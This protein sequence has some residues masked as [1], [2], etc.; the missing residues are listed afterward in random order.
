[1]RKIVVGAMVSMDG[2]MQAQFIKILQRSAANTL[3][4]VNERTDSGWEQCWRW[5]CRRFRATPLLAACLLAES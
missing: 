1:M 3:A 2:V 4:T 5:S